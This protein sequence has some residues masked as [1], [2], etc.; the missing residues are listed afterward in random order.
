M[1]EGVLAPQ[2][3]CI[4]SIARTEATKTEENDYDFTIR[5]HSS[6]AW[7]LSDDIEDNHR[8]PT[9]CKNASLRLLW[10]KNSFK[11]EKEYEWR[12]SH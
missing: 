4:T 10:K 1:L 9:R 8:L 3:K 7:L 11:D 6:S 5:R 2:A 12:L